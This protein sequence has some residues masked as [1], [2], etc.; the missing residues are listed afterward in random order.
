MVK[1]EEL[2]CW[3]CGASLDYLLLPLSR[4]ATCKACDAQI[5]VC[6]MCRYYDVS[7]AKSCREPVAMEVKEKRRA[8]FCDYL[9]LK[10]NAYIPQDIAS[11]N[12]SVSELNALFGL[13]Q[14]E[15]ESPAVDEHTQAERSRQQLNDLFDLKKDE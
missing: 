1:V 8:N 6:K 11:S 3:K 9:E 13:E 5:H 7:V 14:D 4:T 2:V 15:V 12:A 10:L